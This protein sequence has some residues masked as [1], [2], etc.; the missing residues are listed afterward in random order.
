MNKQSYIG[1]IECQQSNQAFL[2]QSA[3][4]P[5]NFRVKKAFAAYESAGTS[6]KQRFPGLE[7]AA[8]CEAIFADSSIGLVLISAPPHQRNSLIGAA[9][10]ANK[11]VQVV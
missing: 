4:L 8:D 10:K 7:L 1:I 9:L 11:Q 5:L 6:L 3:S 2:S